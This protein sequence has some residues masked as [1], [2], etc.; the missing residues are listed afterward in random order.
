MA[1]AAEGGEFEARV[2][3]AQNEAHGFEALETGAVL[4]AVRA[5]EGA[6]EHEAVQGR[7][8]AGLE[9]GLDPQGFPNREESVARER[10][11][12]TGRAR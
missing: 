3:A 1:G 4:E 8:A 9:I 5:A 10:R 2:G 12:Q 7:A 11:G 6:R